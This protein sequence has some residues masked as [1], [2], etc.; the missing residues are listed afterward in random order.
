MIEVSLPLRTY[1]EANGRDH[2]A[3]KAKR[4][5]NARRA[6]LAIPPYP[7]PCMVTLTRLAPRALDDD[8]LCS[9][10]KAFRDGIA[11]RLGCDDRDPRVQWRYGQD[12]AK[13]YGVRVKL[14]PQS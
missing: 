11:D 8:N 1:S 7:L 10:F 6:A 5:Q 4:S 2:W 14:E 9:A 12:K 13:E 3:V